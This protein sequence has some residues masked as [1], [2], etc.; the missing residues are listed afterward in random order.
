M[1]KEIG[2]LILSGFLQLDGAIVIS[3]ATSWVVG[4]GIIIILWGHNVE[5]HWNLR[6]F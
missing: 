4:V 1:K 5:Q 3:Y 6:L 2:I